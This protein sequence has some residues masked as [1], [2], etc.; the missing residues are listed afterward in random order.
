MYGTPM[1]ACIMMYI[2]FITFVCFNYTAL[3][4]F[5]TLI[6]RMYHNLSY[7]LWR[8]VPTANENSV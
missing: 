4:L 1:D 5:A 8:P 3:P 6:S 2:G 7:T